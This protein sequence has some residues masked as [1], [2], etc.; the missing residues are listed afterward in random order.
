MTTG[1]SCEFSVLSFEFSPTR[2]GPRGREGRELNTHNS[3]LNTFC[4]TVL[5]L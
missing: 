4:R 1:L 5:D 2:P 3:N